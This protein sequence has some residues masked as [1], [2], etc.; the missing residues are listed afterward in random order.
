M[1]YQYKTYHMKT[2]SDFKNEYK[3]AFSGDF[4]GSAMDAW[5]ECAGHLN[6]RGLSIPSEWEYSPGLGGGMEPDSYFYD[7]F[8]DCDDELLINIGN[9]LFRYCQF[10]KYK[11]MD[12]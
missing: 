4:W 8:N 5:F 1:S 2:I 9:L 10:L 12:Y 6:N 11:R 3:I 7:I